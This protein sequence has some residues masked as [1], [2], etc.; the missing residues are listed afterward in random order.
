MCVCFFSHMKIIY[1]LYSNIS[2]PFLL[3]RTCSI[4]SNELG[5]LFQIVG[6]EATKDELD[7]MI[8]H[9]DKDKSGEID[10]EGIL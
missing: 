7:A 10:F 5:E 3:P 6:I 8:N 2:F 1:E 4:S 9:I